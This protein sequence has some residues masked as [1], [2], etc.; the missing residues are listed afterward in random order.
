MVWGGGCKIHVRFARND[1]NGGNKEGTTSLGVG[2][3]RVR[4]GLNGEAEE[5]MTI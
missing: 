3:E 1:L 4:N 2:L 5:V